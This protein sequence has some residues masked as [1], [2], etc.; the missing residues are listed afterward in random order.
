ME[1][2]VD[3]FSVGPALKT[4]AQT[5]RRWAWT[6]LRALV[7]NLLPPRRRCPH[8]RRRFRLRPRPF[9][10]HPQPRSRHRWPQSHR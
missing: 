3:R 4:L 8:R 5:P 9:R 10:L 1:D 6:P 2:P 7:P